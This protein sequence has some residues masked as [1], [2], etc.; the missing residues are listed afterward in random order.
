MKLEKITEIT[1]LIIEIITTLSDASKNG[2][3]EI[4][5]SF[6]TTSLKVNLSVLEG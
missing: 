6:F 4:S 3:V 2:W 1:L 5:M